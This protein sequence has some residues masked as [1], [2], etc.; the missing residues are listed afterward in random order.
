MQQRTCTPCVIV[1]T[2]VLLDGFSPSRAAPAAAAVLSC[3]R[4]A[5]PEAASPGCTADISRIVRRA[6]S[7]PPPQRSPDW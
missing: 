3:A 2:A 4:C 1:L 5:G 7:Q 6:E